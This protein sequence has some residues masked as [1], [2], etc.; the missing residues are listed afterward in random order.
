MFEA[1]VEEN[2]GKFFKFHLDIFLGLPE[3]MF[4]QRRI[5]GHLTHKEM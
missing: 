3:D 2:P 1:L 4:V 5:F